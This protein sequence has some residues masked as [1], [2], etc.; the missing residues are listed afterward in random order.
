MKALYRVYIQPPLTLDSAWMDMENAG[1]EILYGSEEEGQVELYVNLSSIEEISSFKWIAACSPYALPPIDWDAQWAAHGYNFH[2]GC[3]T[4]DFQKYERNAPS[5]RLQPGA[6]FGNLSHPTTRLM[7]RMLAQL[8]RNQVVIDIGCGSG[9]LTLSAAAL[10]ASMAYGL[11]IDPNALDHSRKNA[12]LNCLSDRCLF[13]FPSDFNFDTSAQSLLI[14]INMIHS[15]QTIAWDS[16]PSL[17]QTTGACLT[18]GVKREERNL[19]L[20]KTKKWGWQLIDE[21]EESG[22]LAFHFELNNNYRKCYT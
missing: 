18:S 16:L 4:I 3:I 7:L 15:E 1:I 11:D 6:G 8:M 13:C 17:H 20:D 21:Q 5:I 19:Y 10:G 14:L 12:L 9:I 22:W 2:E